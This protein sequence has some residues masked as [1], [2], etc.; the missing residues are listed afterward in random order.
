MCA[1]VASACGLGDLLSGPGL[2]GVVLIY[3][4]PTSLRRGDTIPVAVT[5]QVD[6]EP[7]PTP[8][9]WVTSSDTSII[10]VLP[11]DSIAAR[12]IGVAKLTIR[13]VSAIFTDSLPTIVVPDVRVLP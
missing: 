10:A 8:P 1:A 12:A 6:S 7:L 13:Y 11:G 3:T 9:L 5:V 4:G 2:G